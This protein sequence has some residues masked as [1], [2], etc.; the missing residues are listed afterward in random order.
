MTRNDP[1]NRIYYICNLKKLFKWNDP[2]L[3]QRKNSWYNDNEVEVEIFM[4]CRD[5]IKKRGNSRLFN[6]IS[7]RF[8][9]IGY[10]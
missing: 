9:N 5:I 7:L 8:L 6:N 3:I 4:I 10:K 2:K 1:S